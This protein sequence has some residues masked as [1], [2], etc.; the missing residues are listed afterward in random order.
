MINLSSLLRFFYFE[1]EIRVGHFEIV[2]AMV[3]QTVTFVKR[4]SS[5]VFLSEIMFAQSKRKMTREK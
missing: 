3:G 5:A 4:N 2:R 1:R